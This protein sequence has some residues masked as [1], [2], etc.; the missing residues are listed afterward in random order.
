[1]TSITAKLD[2]LEALPCLEIGS[3]IWGDERYRA[4]QACYRVMR[5]VDDLVDGH[6]ARLGGTI[7]DAAEKERV[8]AVIDDLLT[9]QK[10]PVFA[11]LIE[12]FS[13]PAW[14]WEKWRNAMI[15]DLTHRGFA[16]IEDFF[17]YAEGAAVTPGALFLHL[18]TAQYNGDRYAASPID[19]LKS[20]RPL[21]RFC[22]L[23]HV[24]RDFRKDLNMGINTIPQECGERFHLTVSDL[25]RQARADRLN[26]SMRALMQWY[27]DEAGKYLC[28]AEETLAVLPKVCPQCE[29]TSVR[30]VLALYRAMYEK[31]DPA[32]SNLREEEIK[33]KKSEILAVLA[34]AGIFC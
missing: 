25:A 21:G 5:K 6:P 3:L 28:R 12:R 31:I 1:M 8:I 2:S 27:L 23:V 16:T 20:A 13:V 26:T 19:L 10:D 9:G 18:A 15:Y 22:Y 7:M 17:Q 29:L 11:A 34:R 24:L 33:L 4:F 30:I 32:V 14:I